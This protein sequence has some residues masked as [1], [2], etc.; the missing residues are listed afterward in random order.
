MEI[1]ESE[2]R[3]WVNQKMDTQAATVEDKK[4]EEEGKGRRMSGLT[5]VK[6][7]EGG[8]DGRWRDARK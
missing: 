7:E 8:G 4:G 2:L 3:V 5:D 1:E 6:A